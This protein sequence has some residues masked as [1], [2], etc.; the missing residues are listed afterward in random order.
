MTH[1]TAFSICRLWRVQHLT[2]NS[3]E[4]V[5]HFTEPPLEGT[6]RHR[7]LRCTSFPSL[8][9]S[10]ASQVITPWAPPTAHTGLEFGSSTYFRLEVV[11]RTRRD[12]WFTRLSHL[13]RQVGQL[14]TSLTSTI[15]ERPHRIL[16]PGLLRKLRRPW[17]SRL[18]QR[19][20]GQHVFSA[21]LDAGLRQSTGG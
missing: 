9:A 12:L 13:A 16:L 15:Q 3:A 18:L 11:L 6:E 5:E 21:W 20:P 1:S 4:A 14:A 7:P 10:R 8:R 19:Q 2:T 17:P